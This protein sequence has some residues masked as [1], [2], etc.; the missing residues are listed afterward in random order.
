VTTIKRTSKKEFQT[1]KVV[2]GITEAEV[3]T[4]VQDAIE[5]LIVGDGIHKI[6]VGTTPPVDPEVGDIFINTSI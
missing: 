3:E 6:T 4:I 5:S 1:G 2:S